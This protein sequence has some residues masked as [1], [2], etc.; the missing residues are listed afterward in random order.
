VGMSIN[1]FLLVS[2]KRLRS[3]FGSWFLVLGWLCFAG[4]RGSMGDRLGSKFDGP[5]FSSR[6]MLLTVRIFVSLTRMYR[7]VSLYRSTLHLSHPR[8]YLRYLEDDCGHVKPTFTKIRLDD[9]VQLDKNWLSEGL[10]SLII[11]P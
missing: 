3:W 6:P 1:Y 10:L 5:L 11:N 4:V 8:Q 2:L 7:K 9:E